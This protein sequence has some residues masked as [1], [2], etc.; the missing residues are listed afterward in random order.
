[1]KKKKEKAKGNIT[2]HN[3]TGQTIVNKKNQK[4]S[5]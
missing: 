4:M 5:T 3:S 2:S 1:M